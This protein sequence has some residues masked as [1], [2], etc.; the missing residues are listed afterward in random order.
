MVGLRRAPN[1]S[2]CGRSVPDQHPGGERF[3][4]RTDREIPVVVL[5][6]KRAT[7]HETTIEGGTL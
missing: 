6:R 7:D 3:Q 5:E 2:V 4:A 1:G